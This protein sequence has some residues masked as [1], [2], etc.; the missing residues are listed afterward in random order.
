[1]ADE[2]KKDAEL[3]E[4]KPTAGTQSSPDDTSKQEK[5]E[6]K[7][8][9]NEAQERGF[10]EQDAVW[11]SYRES[12]RKIT[13]QAEQ[14]KT[15]QKFEAEVAPILNAIWEDEE[16]LNAVRGKMT[17]EKPDKP[18]K[19]EGDKEQPTPQHDAEARAVLQT[20]I[21]SSFEESKGIDKLD[22]ESRK[23]V[24]AIIGQELVKWLPNQREVPLNRFKD[25]LEDAFIIAEKKNEKIA[26]LVKTSSQSSDEGAFP[27]ATS[28]GSTS[29]DKIVLTADQKKV[30]SRMGLSEEDYAEGL[31]KLQ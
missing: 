19:K 24:R 9:W 30:A 21:L 8:W 4:E 6:T 14:L 12:E 26:S 29:K 1:M 23:Q 10:K 7:D 3:E 5:D 16:L 28:G 17:G 15:A 20:Q 25:L 22:E 18:V 27:S 13:E 2:P 31:K 11:K